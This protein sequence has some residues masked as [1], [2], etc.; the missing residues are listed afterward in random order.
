M[1]TFAVNYPGKPF[2]APLHKN[3]PL[4]YMLLFG[5]ALLLIASLDV[6]PFLRYHLELAQMPG[7]LAPTITA[8][9]DGDGGGMGMGGAGDAGGFG[10]RLALLGVLLGNLAAVA[11]VEMA[12]RH[13]A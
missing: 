9:G 5:W 12:A 2:T 10:F 3:K 13:L 4:W 11:A 7:A 1:N 6:L 8:D